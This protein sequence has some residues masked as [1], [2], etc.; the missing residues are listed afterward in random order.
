MKKGLLTLIIMAWAL[1]VLVACK[2]GIP[3]PQN[4]ISASARLISISPKMNAPVSPLDAD[5]ENNTQNHQLPL[6]SQLAQ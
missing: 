2:S 5:L 6:Q 1:L 3:G 4:A